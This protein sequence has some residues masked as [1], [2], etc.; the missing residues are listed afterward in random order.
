MGELSGIGGG[1]Q[2][3]KLASDQGVH[4]TP[5]KTVE[6]ASEPTPTDTKGSGGEVKTKEAPKGYA[7]DVEDIFADGSKGDIP[8]FDVSPEEF[9]DNM[10]MD[11]RRLRFKKGSKAAEYMRKTQ[12]NRPFWIRNTKDGYMRKISRQ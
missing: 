9:N 1:V 8:V 4:D 10:K 12:Y 6:P 11:R 3:E 5:N 2:G 7:T